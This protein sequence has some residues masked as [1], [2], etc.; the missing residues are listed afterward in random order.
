MAN[1]GDSCMQSQGFSLTAKQFLLDSEAVQQEIS[2]ISQEI[3]LIESLENSQNE[4]FEANCE[5]SGMEKEDL[6]EIIQDLQRENRLKKSEIDD[7]CKKLT[8]KEEE[9]KEKEQEMRI[10]TEKLQQNSQ[11]I[12]FFR[13]NISNLEEKLKIST[14]YSENTGK[15]DRLEAII[16]RLIL[17]NATLHSQSTIFP[18][19]ESIFSVKGP[20][21]VL[22]VAESAAKVL[23][24]SPKIQR[25]VH[26]S[27]F[28]LLGK[29]SS[30]LQSSDLK[31]GLSALK[32]LKLGVIH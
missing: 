6:I 14:F 29:S 13:F 7:L 1:S 5:F 27:L 10:L 2:I 23:K 24:F 16:D 30:E 19:L 3:P 26:K 17:E 25:F 9:I 21:E 31:S 11:E 15:K 4:G 12:Q 28:I 32:A 20:E 22:K 18:V 8:E